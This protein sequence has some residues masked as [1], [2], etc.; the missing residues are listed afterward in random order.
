MARDWPS[1]EIGR[2]SVLRAGALALGGAALG[3]GALSAC[4]GS[5]GG[6]DSDATTIDHWDWYISQGA[7][8][9]NELKLFG[10]AHPE[11]KVKRTENVQASYDKVFTLAE[12]S[13]NAPDVFF[14][15]VNSMQLN[16]QVQQG[17]LAPLNDLAGPDWVRKF[18]AYSFAEGINMFDGKIYT[19]PFTKPIWF[20]QL[21]I[22]NKVFKDAGLVDASGAVRIPKT[23]DEVTR[24]AEQ[25]VKKSGGRTYGLGFGN[26]STNL[27]GWWFDVFVRAAGSPGGSTGQDFRTGRYTYGSDRNYADLAAL[28]LEWKQKG[29]LYPNSLSV[30]DEVARANF[31]RGK[32]GMTVGGVWN[33]ATWT[34]HKFTDYSATTLVGPTEKRAAYFYARPGGTLMAIN[35]KSKHKAEAFT[36]F[37]WWHSKAAGIRWVQDYQQDLSIHPEANDPKKIKFKP[38]ADYV[39][40]SELVIPGPRPEVRNP[41]ISKV[42]LAPVQPD[43]GTVMAGVLSGQIKDIGKALTELADS[44]QKALEDGIKAAQDK[45]AKVSLSDY[46]FDGWDPAKPFKWSIPEY[47]A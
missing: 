7:W 11:I 33:Q 42:V 23:W 28:M 27:L 26:G 14:I 22:N 45:G 34:E 1:M 31:E 40:L 9:K 2:R 46:A 19:A 29:Y 44:S 35:A 8:V 36:W 39:A 25:I 20:A 17:W 32:F 38:F 13:N 18:P 5:G 30:S 16:E 4:G 43:L 47:P 15:T 3:G 24:A 12:R 41:D 21:Y 10:K 37:D 6:G